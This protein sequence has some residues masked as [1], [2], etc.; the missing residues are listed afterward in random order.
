MYQLKAAQ[1]LTAS[2]VEILWGHLV[3]EV[4]GAFWAV[5]GYKILL[6]VLPPDSEGGLDIPGSRMW[7]IT[8]K[9]AI[10]IRWP[11]VAAIA[12]FVGTAMVFAIFAVLKGPN[13]VRGWRYW[14]PSGSAFAMGKS[15]PMA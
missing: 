4:W 5:L 8:G 11:G 7:M 9:A 10:D 3:G 15:R 12:P 6:S 1:D 13:A 14:L 2:P